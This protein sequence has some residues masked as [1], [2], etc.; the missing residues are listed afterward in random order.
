CV[1]AARGRWPVVAAATRATETAACT[2]AESAATES[3]A[4]S[5]TESATGEAAATEAA[6]S[7]VTRGERLQRSRT[8]SAHALHLRARGVDHRALR[9]IV[10]PLPIEGNARRG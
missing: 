4:K 1:V 5:S 8:T 3:A 9:R 7:S 2:A 10:E 6:E